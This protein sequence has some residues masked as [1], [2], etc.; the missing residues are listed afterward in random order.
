MTK[1]CA[2]AVVFLGVIA[3]GSA[4]ASVLESHC[5]CRITKADA[6]DCNLRAVVLDAGAI[7]K[8]SNFLPGKNEKC[9][10]AC[11]RVLADRAQGELCTGLARLGVPLPW[12]GNLKTCSRVGASG[13]HP[14][15]TRAVACA[16]GDVAPRVPDGY[17]KQTFADEFK[18]A[19]AGASPE[20]QR[21]FERKPFCVEMYK[22]GASVCPDRP[23]G[24]DNVRHLNKCAWTLLHRQ[25]SWGPELSSYDTRQVEVRPNEDGGVLVLTTRAVR[26]DGTYLLYDARRDRDGKLISK[27]PYKKADKW[28]YR[29]QYDCTRTEWNQPSRI[30]CPFV[31]GALLSQSF[32]G[33]LAAEPVGFKQKYGRFEFRAKIS[34]GASPGPSAMWMLPQNGEWP[35]AG[36]IDV[37]EQDQDGEEPFQTFHTGTC[38]ADQRP[39]LNL[40]A[41]RARGGKE[42]HIMKAG[43]TKVRDLKG[44]RT[45]FWKGFHTY[46]VEWDANTVR[47]LVDD[48]VRNEIRAGEI[49]EGG[50]LNP[51]AG[52]KAERRWMPMWIPQSEFYFIL[53]QGPADL[54][55]KI[56]GFIPFN[57]ILN[58]D[59][60]VPFELKIDYIR[61]YQ[62]CETPADFCPSGD[63]FNVQTGMCQGRA[64]PY[65][66]ACAKKPYR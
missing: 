51:P 22:S 35:G 23:G 24:F 39:T 2:L 18:G 49:K 40:A 55:R 66:S 7:G 28:Q 5:W 58:P 12:N 64:G 15:T 59:N 45:S 42:F 9:R 61:A 29:G 19:P 25:N 44:D 21:C 63:A 27:E 20:L 54:K 47:F 33:Q 43:S 4:S 48:Q 6:G 36:E 60:F 53:T 34:Y 38:S 11:D 13:D 8:F 17:W 14:G 1:L 62:K 50:E 46:A 57:R 31:S 52:K 26:P 65:P 32:S 3:A 16:A 10:A 41:C 30:K 56:L 37:M